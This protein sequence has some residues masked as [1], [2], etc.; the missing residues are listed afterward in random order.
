MKRLR[1][2]PHLMR[3]TA[4]VLVSSLLD[5]CTSW[6]VQPL[7]PAHFSEAHA[8][9][10]AHVTLTSGAELTIHQ[11]VVAGDSLIGTGEKYATS[12]GW[13]PGQRVAIPLTDIRQV[14]VSQFEGGKTVALVAGALTA[15]IIAWL[16]SCAANGCNVN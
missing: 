3:L 9:K 11:P 10:T 12:G 14:T 13:V 8:P 4:L 5:A 15:L 1:S 7:D 2:S 6:H 16:I